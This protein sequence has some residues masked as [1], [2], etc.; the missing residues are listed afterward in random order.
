[1][2]SNPVKT[3]LFCL[4]IL[5]NGAVLAAEA[6][7][8]FKVIISPEARVRVMAGE[9]SRELTQGEWREF[10]IEIENTAGITSALQ[11]ESGNLI[12]PSSAVPD[13]NH[14]LRLELIPTGPLTG[15]LHEKRTLRLLTQQSGVRSAVLNAN[16]GQGTQD[17]GFRSDLLV[18]F[19]IQPATTT[20]TS[21]GWWAGNLNCPGG[22]ADVPSLMQAQAF[23]IG[24]FQSWVNDENPWAGRTLPS[25]LITATPDG[26]FYSSLAGRDERA[27]GPLQ[28]FNLK[29]PFPLAGYPAK[30]AEWPPSVFLL[31]MAKRRGAWVDAGTSDS[32]DFPFWL[33]SGKLDSIGLAPANQGSGY[34]RNLEESTSRSSTWQWSQELYFRALNC[35]IKL[36]PSSGNSPNART[37]VHT[38]ESLTWQSWWDQFKAGRVIVS[39]GLQLRVTANSTMPGDLLK[40]AQ[41]PLE[42]LLAGKL[43]PADSEQA[44][45][46]IR[47]G[48]SEIIKLPALITINESGWFLVRA[49]TVGDPAQFAMTAPWYVEIGGQAMKPRKQDTEFFREWARQRVV[50]VNNAIPELDKQKSAFAVLA[51]A[52]SFWQEKAGTVQKTTR[53]RGTILD[54][55]TSATMPARIYIQNAQGSWFFPESEGGTAVRYEKRNFNNLLSSEN[56]TTLSA[57]PWR[58]DL[59]PG[60]YTITVERGKEWFPLIREVEVGEQSLDL[61]LP[62]QRWVNMAAEGWF[63][64][65]T[66]VHRMIAELPNVMLAEDL[67]VAFPLSYWC[68][69]AQE[70][71]YHYDKGADPSKPA[72]LIIVDP[73]HVIWPCNTEWEIF[74][75]NGHDHTLGAVFALGHSTPIKLGAPLLGPIARE[76]RRQGALLDMDK[77]D[78]PWAM[79]LPPIMGIDLYELSNNHV[80]RVPFALGKWTTPAPEWMLGKASHEGDERAWLEYTHQVYWALLNAGQRLRPSAGTASGVHP[81]PLGFSRV[82]VHCPEG[83]SYE[84]WRQGLQTGRSF[85][86]TGPICISEVTRARDGAK[87][88]AKVSG[89]LP[90]GKLEI[91]VNGE[92]T[93]SIEINSRDAVIDRTVPLNGTS[94]I[95]LRLW[96]PQPDGR[97][98]FAHTSPVWFD[99]P[100]KPLRPRREQ[101]EFLAQRVRDEI[102]RSTPVLPGAAIQEYQ[103]ALQTWQQLIEHNEN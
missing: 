93:E 74:G 60:R 2:R 76:A 46:L 63:S 68:L 23:H 3:F 58:A 12:P 41:G 26:R 13:R 40:T 84:N 24:Q 22:L 48:H 54:A 45:E 53:I 38:G 100:E 66:H 36:P 51:A 94:W 52:E 87:I 5:A 71:P 1:M 59:P 90:L 92:I 77:P 37:E 6:K 9:A 72:E 18:S 78:W 69:H 33:A 89:Q 79:A 42:V 30:T 28:M 34:S 14:W 56:H 67:N 73:T 91:I 75:I 80:W 43:E 86:T 98:R 31:E 32:P 97:S 65:E 102:R 8:L 64:G 47:N 101:A 19:K 82:Y 15:N 17:L 39:Q 27:G 50:A 88:H 44:I 11:I 57:H 35:G 25:P 49:T 85:V 55:G 83:F 16:A 95:A 103:N 61:E 81:V 7:P 70:I 4:T 20:R 21:D 96:E 10:E 29:E 62:V 99:D